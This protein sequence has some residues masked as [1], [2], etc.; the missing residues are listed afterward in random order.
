MP[1]HKQ[2][3]TTTYIPALFVCIILNLLVLDAYIL[4]NI[5]HTESVLGATT[6]AD[7]C[8]QACI[9]RINQIA[10]KTTSSSVKEFYIPLGTG[11]NTSDVWTDVSGASAYID[12]SSYGKIK[13]VT[14]EANLYQPSGS[15]RIWIR[16]NNATEG[17]TIMGSELSTDN[18]G[19][20]T[21]TSPGLTLDAGNKLYQ[22]QIKTQLKGLTNLTQSRIHIVTY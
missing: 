13:K 11:T 17:R 5:F 9:A 1:S 18:S 10:G 22:V 8:P 6:S 3:Q 14:F 19:P 21:L 20:V 4:W 2:K 7:T 16:L 12:S 15:Q